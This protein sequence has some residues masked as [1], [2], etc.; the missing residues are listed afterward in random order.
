MSD[1][2]FPWFEVVSMVVSLLIP[3][4]GA[5]AGVWWRLQSQI[6]ACQASLAEYKLQ[7]AEK[8]ATNTAIKEVETRVVEAINRLGDRVENYFDSN[9]NRN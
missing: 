4:A 1:Y 5:L 8:Y 6:A 7:V 9:R 2:G 3:G